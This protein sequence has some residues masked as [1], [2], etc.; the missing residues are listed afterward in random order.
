[1]VGPGTVPG[2][3]TVYR[4]SRYGLMQ[5]NT[6]DDAVPLPRNPKVAEPPA[7][8]EPL[9]ATLLTDTDDP[10]ATRVPFQTWVM[11]CPFARSQR[12]VHP[13]IAD[14]P[15]VTIT[16]PWKPPGHELTVR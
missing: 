12:T 15:A 4:P 8:T 1:M 3:I 9:Y 2:P 6:G 10:P 14:A 11:V 7:G 13:L 5:V 16:S